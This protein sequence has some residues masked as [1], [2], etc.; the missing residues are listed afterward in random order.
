MIV[1]VLSCHSKMSPVVVSSFEATISN[2]GTVYF[3]VARRA[4]QAKR[5]PLDVCWET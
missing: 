4:A 3:G 2:N 1:T 5:N